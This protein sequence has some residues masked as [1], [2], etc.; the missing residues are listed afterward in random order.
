MNILL[1]AWPTVIYLVL[2]IGFIYCTLIFFFYAGWKK[3]SPFH[4]KKKI[5]ETGISVI[6][7]VRNE[8]EHLPDLIS[9]LEQQ[10]YPK[11]HY[12][13]IL[14]NDHSTDRSVEII[15]ESIADSSFIRLTDNPG[16]GKKQAILHGANLSRF[17]F[18]L[19]SDAD[20][21]RGRN[22]LAAFAGFLYENKPRMILGPV[23]PL[24][25]SGFLEQ[26]K[27]IEFI[28]LVA[29]GAG[30]AGQGHPILANGANLGF[31]K[32]ELD[33]TE[34]PLKK[35]IPSGDDLFLMLRIKK[36][37]P[38]G[39]QFLKSVEATVYT[40]LPGG[41]KP[42]LHQ[43]KRWVSKSRYYRDFD[44]IYTAIVVL[45]TNLV[46]LL[47][48][49]GGLFSLPYLLGFLI[50]WLLKLFPDVLL[51]QAATRFFGEEK[52]MKYFLPTQ[53]F[54]FIYVSFTA[55]TGLSGCSY[56]WK[57]RKFSG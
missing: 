57:G 29:S 1:Q 33:L 24:T 2:P 40:R 56:E 36:K 15:K 14:V 16:F 18:I 27:A 8:E 44:L 5:P 32:E 43:R 42:F 22:W 7:P 47:C 20:C 13:V 3:I 21:R 26:A 41:W 53:L 28:S 45:L 34:D 25:G 17:E 35:E 37:Y 6:I 48:L 10:N 55:F 38:Q 46:L 54:Y 31:Y 50:L 30:A 23:L 39:I 12:E 19:T 49:V 51:L 4:L 11:E 9:E 52:L